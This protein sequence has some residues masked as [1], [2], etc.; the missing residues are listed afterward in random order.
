[1]D[2]VF[3][4]MMETV[5]HSPSYIRFLIDPPRTILPYWGT[6]CWSLL[7]TYLA[8]SSGGRFSRVYEWIFMLTSP[9]M[10]MSVSALNSGAIII[11]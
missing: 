3:I 8:L 1:M 6:Q 10:A 4:S 9:F 7:L 2:K 5:Q 11:M